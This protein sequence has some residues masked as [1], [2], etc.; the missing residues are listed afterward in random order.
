MVLAFTV[1]FLVPTYTGGL[2]PIFNLKQFK[3]FMHIPTFRM[4]TIKQVWQLIQQHDYAFSVDQ[5]D[6]YLQFP[7]VKHHHFLHFVW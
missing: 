1:M 6:V 2:C 4:P 5:K 7:I 3:C